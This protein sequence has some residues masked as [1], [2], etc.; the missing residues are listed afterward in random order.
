MVF[1]G[2]VPGPSF[3]NCTV[4]GMASTQRATGALEEL[5]LGA[6]KAPRCL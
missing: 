6:A 4:A 1:P 3:N 2:T 5:N